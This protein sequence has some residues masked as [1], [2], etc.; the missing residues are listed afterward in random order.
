M[1]T[2]L[3]QIRYM[4]LLRFIP[5][6]YE[7]FAQGGTECTFC[8]SSARWSGCTCPR[9]RPPSTM[10]LVVWWCSTSSPSSGESTLSL[11]WERNNCPT[12]CLSVCLSLRLSV[13]TCM[14][15]TVYICLVSVCQ[16]FFSVCRST[17]LFISLFSLI[18]CIS[19]FTSPSL[20]HLSLLASP[21]SL[22]PSLS[23]ALQDG[24]LWSW[25]KLWEEYPHKLMRCVLYT[26]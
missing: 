3:R 18:S 1:G 23:H 6:M 11:R 26:V 12:V 8:V 7:C 16:P 20:S 19:L 2:Y 24:Y 10:T 13:S 9:W 14:Y 5:S 25:S 21:S 4:S 22:L 15:Y 17:C